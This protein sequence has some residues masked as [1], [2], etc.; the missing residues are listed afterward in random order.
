MKTAKKVKDLGLWFIPLALL[1]SSCTSNVQPQPNNYQIRA[2]TAS[3]GETCRA[4][5]TQI[6]LQKWTDIGYLW[7]NMAAEVKNTG[8]TPISVHNCKLDLIGKD[9]D[10]LET[11]DYADAL[12]AIV[13]PSQSAYISEYWTFKGIDSL[14]FIRDVNVILDY[15][16]TDAR[17][18]YLQVK[19]LK[20]FNDDGRIKV[21]GRIANSSSRNVDDVVYAVALWDE[22]GKLLGVMKETLSIP[23]EQGQETGFSTDDPPL[24]M[25]I[26][27]I[28]TM[29]A[30]ACG[31]DMD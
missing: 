17:I 29:T 27:R 1:I 7:V 20:A 11:I 4:E 5:V 24:E 19:D 3:P 21:T 8:S 14:D 22:E 30:V 6:S 9:N 2:E 26:G 18:E 15:D 12:P 25:D 16:R 13:M 10:I 23:L 28:V 31:R